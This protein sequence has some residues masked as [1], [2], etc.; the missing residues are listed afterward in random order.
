MR[1]DPLHGG[2]WLAVAPTGESY[3]P[4]QTATRARAAIARLAAANGAARR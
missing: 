4:Y 3:G 1:P 2:A